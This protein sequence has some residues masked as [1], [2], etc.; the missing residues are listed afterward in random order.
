MHRMEYYDFWRHYSV[1]A[2]N[3]KE[4]RITFSRALEDRTEDQYYIETKYQFSGSARKPPGM[5]KKTF[6]VLA[7]LM[8]EVLSE[9]FGWSAKN[10]KHYS[11]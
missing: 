10:D 11:R 3:F 4:A 6:G 9:L 5:G 2:D 8:E 7:W 1:K